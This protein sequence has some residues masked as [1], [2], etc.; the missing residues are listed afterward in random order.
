MVVPNGKICL[1]YHGKAQAGIAIKRDLVDL[2]P[3][4]IFRTAKVVQGA[5]GRVVDIANV[6]TTIAKVGTELVCVDGRIICAIILCKGAGHNQCLL[7]VLR[8]C[9]CLTPRVR[10]EGWY[11]FKVL[12]VR[13]NELWRFWCNLSDAL[14][15]I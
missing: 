6:F 2:D 10:K 1:I 3:H 7:A 4:F 12:R 15:I 14:L 13:P 11:V 5:A 8:L 9:T